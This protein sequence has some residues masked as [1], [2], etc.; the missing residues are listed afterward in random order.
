MIVSDLGQIDRVG[1]VLALRINTHLAF[2]RVDAD[3][4]LRDDGA[5]IVALR[6]AV[7]APAA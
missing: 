7:G 5:Q 2:R 3:I 6:R 1:H 4:T